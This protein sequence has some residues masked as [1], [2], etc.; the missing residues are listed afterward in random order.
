MQTALL[1]ALPTALV[2][3]FFSS[4]VRF[5]FW[6]YTQGLVIVFKKVL[7][8]MKSASVF[9]GLDVWV[10]NLFTPMYGDESFSGRLISFLV[11]FAMVIGKGFAVFVWTIIA[12]V[13]FVVYLLALPVAVFGLIYQ[14]AF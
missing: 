6:W 11:R 4:I 5:P 7:S 9:F 3:E 2:R 8:S 12:W 1:K 10:R 14:F 13:L